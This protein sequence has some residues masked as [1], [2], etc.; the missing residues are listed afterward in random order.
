MD[1]MDWDYI[2]YGS[3]EMQHKHLM[4]GIAKFNKY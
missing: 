1:D 4:S 3:K 2:E